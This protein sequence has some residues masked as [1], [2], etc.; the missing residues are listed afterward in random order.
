MGGEGRRGEIADEIGRGMMIV[1][2]SEG[3]G[4]GGRGGGGRRE[5][6]VRRRERRREGH[7][8]RYDGGRRGQERE[9]R[10]SRDGGERRRGGGGRT[11]Q[12]RTNVQAIQ[13]ARRLM[14]SRNARDLNEA[15][16][17]LEGVTKEFADNP[18]AFHELGNCYVKMKR[19]RDS[20]EALRSAVQIYRD[21]DDKKIGRGL[22]DLGNAYVAAGV[23][24][25]IDTLREAVVTA[26]GA[27]GRALNDL[28][29]MRLPV[30]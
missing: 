24:N 20:V 25:A 12:T 1:L 5:V 27:K 30:M 29:M 2:R 17:I 21:N 4:R 23:S 28:A 9:G 22:N 16:G 10:W 13:Q 8:G 15:A 3:G 6:G 11:H 26:R 7:R 18:W 14:K 19:A